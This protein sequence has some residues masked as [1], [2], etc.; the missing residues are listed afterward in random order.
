MSRRDKAARPREAP[1][2]MTLP[3]V[4]QRRFWQ[5]HFRH[6]TYRVGVGDRVVARVLVVD[7]RC[8]RETKVIVDSRDPEGDLQSV[9][10]RPAQQAARLLADNGLAGAV[11][12]TLRHRPDP[13]N[14]GRLDR[15]TKMPLRQPA[16]PA[17]GIEAFI[18]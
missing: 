7:G 8:A 3:S 4:S 5:G 15:R 1:M 9:R 10:V 12:G 2:R 13:G 11:D 17:P 18:D 6:T 14:A 16:G